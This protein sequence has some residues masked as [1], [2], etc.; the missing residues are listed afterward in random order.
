MFSLLAVPG[1]ERCCLRLAD[2]SD[3]YN[4]I[5]VAILFI[6]IFLSGCWAVVCSFEEQ[7]VEDEPVE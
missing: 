5:P 1:A 7:P 2:E 6:A 3:P 4:Y